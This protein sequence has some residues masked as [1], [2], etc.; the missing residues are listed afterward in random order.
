MIVSQ[1][2]DFST[3]H[4]TR[5]SCK[6]LIS[7]TKDFFHPCLIQITRDNA[8]KKTSLKFTGMLICTLDDVNMHIHV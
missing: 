3:V 5:L 1:Y 8:R 4:L 6:V 7:F 2:A